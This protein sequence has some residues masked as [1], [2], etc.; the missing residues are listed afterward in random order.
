[1]IQYSNSQDLVQSATLVLPFEHV[2][3]ADLPC[4]GGKGANLGELAAAGLPVPPGFCVTTA[5]FER[6]LDSI[7][8]AEGLYASLDALP[9]DDVE[10]ARQVGQR[11][12]DV[13]HQSPIPADIAHA[14]V[15][16]WQA[17]GA[18]HGFAVRS[19]A[20]TEDLPDASFAGQHDSVLNVRGET[21]LLNAVRTCWASLFAD[22]AILYR[23]RQGID[24]R[25]ARMAV[26][27]QC[28]VE[29]HVSGIMF[30]ADPVTGNRAHIV[31]N[32][33]YGLGEALVTGMVAPD[34]YEVD[35]RRRRVVTQEVVDKRLLL[36][37]LPGAGGVER[38]EV[39]P[40]LRTA[41]AL[42]D[43]QAIKLAALGAR[44]E[45]HYG[46][47]QDI[48]WA[49]DA[50]RFVMLQ[51]RPI[52]TLYP[53]PRPAPADDSLHVY[54]SFSHFQV[55]TDPL[56][57]LVMSLWRMIFP[58]GRPPG[59]IENPFVAVAGGRLYIDLSPLLRHRLLGRSV[60][61]ALANLDALAAQAIATVAARPAFR[62]QGQALR[63][64]T[65]LRWQAP[66]LRRT[67]VRLFWSPPEGAS[68]VGLRLM[69]RSLAR[70]EARLAA[71]PDTTARLMVAVALL[72]EVAP[73][74]LRAW[75]PYF[76]AGELAHRLLERLLRGA[77]APDDLVAAVR[78]LHG[79]VVTGMNL[80]VGD[81]ADSVRQSP[82]L[83]RHLARAGVDTRTLVDTAAALPGGAAFAAAWQRF[84]ARYGMR[85]PAEIDLRRPRWHEDPASLL[86]M[87]LSNVRENDVGAHHAHYQQLAAEGAAAAQRLVQAARRGR[88]GRLRAPLVRRLVRVT[89]QLLPTR[90]HHK[91]WLI[92]LLGLVKPVLLEA[93]RQLVAARRIA[94][95]DDVWFLTM[96]ELQAALRSS[97]EPLHSLVAERRRAF[98]RFHN[99]RPPRV[100]TSDGEVPI[101]TPTAVNLPP[102]AL[103]GTPASSGSVEGR[104]RVVRDPL[105]ATLNHGEILV[106]PFTDP[107]WTPLFIT[108]AAV[109][110]EVGGV[111]THGS[112]IA[113]EYGIP[114]VVGVVDAT[115]RIRTG[116][117]IRVNGTA[118]Y[119]ELLEPSIISAPGRVE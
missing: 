62:R 83:A 49:L 3:A 46:S 34:R 102:G 51:A 37:A 75:I 66:L 7:A 32:A 97:P 59:A 5:A 42:T 58:A 115:S 47:P 45:A 91:F 74:I 53:R 70:A 26:V 114:A 113:R 60:P 106:A 117:H 86:R 63:T 111:M 15:E 56:P 35:K 14:L 54:F 50:E 105:A 72:H 1:M 29:P 2:R 89:R 31:I 27:V 48:E 116:Q 39:P 12:R 33:S 69:D 30:T 112:V 8:C 100:I 84:I 25:S 61:A 19:S 57:D 92:R 94:E 65:L 79:N 80:A 87:V 98:A 10:R 16:E 36:R 24:H 95:V 22:R 44:I 68:E 118:G 99:L 119:V 104:A 55:M 11:V 81:L 73:T 17:L 23:L 43:A 90:D 64:R 108:A 67:L 28:M 71:A 20:T 103:S 40:T 13:L 88:W 101:V 107:G 4:V 9:P 38:V 93:G 82:E 85:A 21:A 96:P 110:T 77:A 52:T 109:V 78:G 18:E 6:F 76:V 41:P